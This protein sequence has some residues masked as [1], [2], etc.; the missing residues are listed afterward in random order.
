MSSKESILG[1]IPKAWEIRSICEVAKV[2]DS[3]HQT[4]VY[5]DAGIPMVRVTDIKEDGLNL[6]NCLKVS[7]EVYE[8]FTKNHIPQLGDILISRVGTYGVFCYVKT[9]EGFCLGQNTAIISPKINSRYLFYNLI[10]KRTKQ[11]IDNFAVGSTQKTISLKNI[12]NIKTPICGKIEQKAIADTLSCLD[13]KIELNNRI[14]NNLEEMAQTIFKS[15]FIDFDPFQD[16][17]FE[18]SELGR[19]PK[20]WRVGYIDE[21]IERTISGDWGKESDQGTYIKKVVCIRGAD[22]SEIAMGKRGKPPIRFILNKNLEKK[23]L[24]TDQ[25]I[26]EISGGSPTQSTGRTALI[27]NELLQA[28]EN[29]LICTNFCRALSFKQKE[30]STFVY[31]LMQYLYRTDIFFLYENGT[32][33][34]KNLDTANL[35]GKHKVVIPNENALKKYYKLYHT[36][37]KSIYKNGFQSDKLSIVRD[38]LLPKLMS[39]EI[40]VPLQEVN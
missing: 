12:K 27:T 2:I 26:I 31:S 35:F 32:T 10:N 15:W 30:S 20:G 29:P 18:D 16:G 40:R 38:T 13:D 34:I 36:L 19:I 24:F 4:P 6:G 23:Q 37:L 25:I 8:M 33:G 11:Q 22:I 5:S 21:L 14:N 3:L 7:S 9:K 17:E 1:S 39:G 28:Y